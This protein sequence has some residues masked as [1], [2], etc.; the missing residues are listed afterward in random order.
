[1]GIISFITGSLPL[2]RPSLDDSSPFRR[3]LPRPVSMANAD[4]HG[5]LMLFMPLSLVVDTTP[6][7]VR[8]AIFPYSVNEGFEY[9][10]LVEGC[11]VG[12]FA[13]GLS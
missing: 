4:D 7:L 2:D 5:G 13:G 3:G 10:F 11:G 1:M 12:E 8:V 9:S 6:P